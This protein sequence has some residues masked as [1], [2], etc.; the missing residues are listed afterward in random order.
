MSRLDLPELTRILRECA[1]VDE[2]VDLEGDILDMAFPEL[3]Y[4]SLALLQTIGVIQ[5][6]FGIELDD[7]AAGTET[8]REFLA[9]VNA[10]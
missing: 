3:G 10:A 7:S 5:R 9:L 8:P 6:E 4:D 1:G 2:A